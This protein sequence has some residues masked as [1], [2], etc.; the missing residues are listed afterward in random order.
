MRF[1][2]CADD[3]SRVSRRRTGKCESDHEYGDPA[4][5]AERPK[6]AA[7]TFH[8]CSPKAEIVPA[9]RKL[10]PLIG[11]YLSTDAAVEPVSLP[12]TSPTATVFP[13]D[14][15]SEAP[16]PLAWNAKPLLPSGAN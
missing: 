2:A 5:F 13:V 16:L 9:T 14:V 6:K 1:I 3:A 10:L 4:T 12:I 11:P 15:K 8:G 7:C